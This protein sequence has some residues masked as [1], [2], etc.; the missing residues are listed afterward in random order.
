MSRSRRI[1]LLGVT[2]Y[3]S[4]AALQD[5]IRYPISPQGC[6]PTMGNDDLEDHTKNYCF[7]K[8][9]HES[10]ILNGVLGVCGRFENRWKPVRQYWDLVLPTRFVQAW[11]YPS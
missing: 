3:V 11:E 4:G 2:G 1:A 9:T 8:L 5:E 6:I 7:R 10:D